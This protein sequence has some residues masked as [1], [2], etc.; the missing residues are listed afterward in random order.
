MDTFVDHINLHYGDAKI[1]LFHI[2]TKKASLEDAIWHNHCYYEIHVVTEG[3]YTCCFEEKQI[4][5]HANEFL[6]IPPQLHHWSTTVEPSAPTKRYILSLAL[7]Q[8]EGPEKLW[9]LFSQA[10]QSNILAPIPFSGLHRDQLDIFLN[11]P[12]YGTVLGMCK[13]KHAAAALVLW[14]FEH[15]LKEDPL[16][17]RSDTDTDILIDNLVHR[18]DISLDEIAE[19]AN[20]S[21]R[22]VSR[23][24]R[25]RY[26]STLSQLRSTK[27]QKEP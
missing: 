20:Y 3:S 21:K 8:T 10:L 14:L 6:I 24:I 5:L 11:K 17:A 7:E 4:T 22:H 19:A 9:S 13:L 18:P 1:S 12:L 23:L 27:K 26:G 25:Q 15:L 16:L 2:G